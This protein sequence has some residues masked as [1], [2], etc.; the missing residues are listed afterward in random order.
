MFVPVFD[1]VFDDLIL[2]IDISPLL[3][4]SRSKATFNTF[5][6]LLPIESMQIFMSILRAFFFDFRSTLVVY[7][8]HISE[9]QVPLIRIIRILMNT[10][11]SQ[12]FKDNFLAFKLV[13]VIS[14]AVA[15][16]S[17]AVGGNEVFTA[18]HALPINEMWSHKYFITK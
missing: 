14:G 6:R 4:V 5:I 2:R 17:V 18:V 15:A 16:S 7:F 13:A 12:V 8:G 9:E 1:F 10:F 3:F 11:L